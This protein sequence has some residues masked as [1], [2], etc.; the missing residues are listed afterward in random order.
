MYVDSFG[1]EMLDS[2]PFFSNFF[3]ITRMDFLD[4]TTMGQLQNL[5]KAR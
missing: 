1:T 4:V 3:D 5:P 2:T